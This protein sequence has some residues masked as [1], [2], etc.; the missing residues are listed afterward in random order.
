VPVVD[1]D[2]RLLSPVAAARML[3]V[4]DSK[5]IEWIRSGEL[6]A[7]NLATSTK[8]ERPRLKIRPADLEDFLLSRRIIPEMKI[9]RRRRRADEV[10]EF[11]K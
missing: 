3:G 7:S 9:T 8:G 5:I 1:S 11:F 10:V 4:R 2:G 6:K